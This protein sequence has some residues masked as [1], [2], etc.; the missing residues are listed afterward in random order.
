PTGPVGSRSQISSTGGGVP[1]LTVGAY[2]RVG[3]LNTT[4]SSTQLT[5]SLVPPAG[6][7]A[8]AQLA[9]SQYDP[10]TKRY[11]LVDLGVAPDGGLTVP[12]QN[13]LAVLNSLAVDQPGDKAVSGYTLQA[14]GKGLTSDAAI[15]A[16]FGVNADP[17]PLPD[18]F[19]VSGAPGAGS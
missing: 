13:G 3:N 11:K 19:T 5:V 6:N 12:F 17:T 8:G 16:A 1:L 15:S 4:D 9:T 2:D 14:A 7:P 10:V 18:T